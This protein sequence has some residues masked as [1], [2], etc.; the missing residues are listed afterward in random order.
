MEFAGYNPVN[1]LTFDLYLRAA[2]ISAAALFSAP[3]RAL[4]TGGAICLF[5]IAF[6]KEGLKLPRHKTSIFAG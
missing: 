2:V 1:G 4:L 3:D 5:Q 6:G